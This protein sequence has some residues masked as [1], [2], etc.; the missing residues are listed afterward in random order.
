[1]EDRGAR[2]VKWGDPGRSAFVADG[3]TNRVD[4]RYGGYDHGVI[5]SACS[6]LVE[7]DS[8]AVCLELSRQINTL[9][10]HPWVT[11]F[12]SIV[13]A[14]SAAY[15]SSQGSLV[16]Q[17]RDRRNRGQREAIYGA[18]DS[19][20]ALLKNWTR[21]KDWRDQSEQNEVTSAA[22]NSPLSPHKELQLITAFNKYVSRIK[23]DDLRVTFHEWRDTARMYFHGNDAVS[24]RDE[25]DLRDKAIKQA[26]EKA[27]S[28]D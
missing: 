6:G 26:G 19:M 12:I 17:K 7:P 16:S 18:Q 5:L 24:F 23:E 2:C 4:F 8:T 13:G 27:M 3:C 20:E 10:W 15:L 21:L 14:I 28:L 11:A 1:M 9:R 25:R 22:T